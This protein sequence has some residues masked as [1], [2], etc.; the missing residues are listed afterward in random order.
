[1]RITRL[2]AVVVP[3]AA[4]LAIGLTVV[5]A[6]ASVHHVAASKRSGPPYYLKNTDTGHFVKSAGDNV[7]VIMVS[8]STSGRMSI[9]REF[10][11]NQGGTVYYLYVDQNGR[12]LKEDASEPGR[13][14]VPHGC[15]HS[16]DTTSQEEYIT[17]SSDGIWTTWYE[18]NQAACGLA[19]DNQLSDYN[20]QMSNRCDDFQADHWAYVSTT[21]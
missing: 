1:M 9:A 7:P 6:A 15:D 13:P 19:S 3:A 17:D 2:A 11:T 4:A 14:M 20:L 5:P 8:G 12:C 10:G 16:G 21:G 18:V